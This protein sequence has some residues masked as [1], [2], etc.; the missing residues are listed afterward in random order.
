MALWPVIPH[1]QCERGPGHNFR[2]SASGL[3]HRKNPALK[4]ILQ[5][6]TQERPSRMGA[7]AKLAI[8][9]IA[10]IVVTF[11][12]V[13]ALVISEQ[14]GP[15]RLVGSRVERAISA[16][17]Q[18][19]DVQ[20]AAPARRAGSNKCLS[21]L[22]ERIHEILARSPVPTWG[23]LVYNSKHG[24]ELY[25]RSADRSFVPASGMKLLTAAAAL[26]RLAENFN[27]TTRI[28]RSPNSRN[29]VCLVPVGDPTFSDSHLNSLVRK[30]LEALKLPEGSPIEI[31]VVGVGG[32]EEPPEVWE[33]GDISQPYGAHAGLAV[34]NDNLINVR[35][36]P[37]QPGQPLVASL[38]GRDIGAV[39]L[40]T[41][42][43]MTGADGYGPTLLRVM[44][45]VDADSRLVLKTSGTLSA[46]SPPVW[47]LR[48]ARP[49]GRLLTLHLQGALSEN[50]FG[51]NRA[52]VVALHRHDQ[53]GRCAF[54]ANESAVLAS[55]SSRTLVPLLAR[56]LEYSD[57]L[58]TESL[59]MALGN[60]DRRVGLQ[61]VEDAV[62]DVLETSDAQKVPGALFSMH[63][64]VMMD[65]AG[66]SRQNLVSPRLFVS[67]LEGMRKSSLLRHCLPVSGRSGT[68]AWRMRGTA[69]E[70]I[71]F[72]KT[73]TITGVSSLSGYLAH[74]TL[75]LTTFSIVANNVPGRVKGGSLRSVQDAILVALAEARAADLER[76]TSCE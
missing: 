65:A 42:D 40:D 54:E 52:S 41:S 75:G 2:A 49:A 33:A 35:V 19:P 67:L 31:R 18:G 43:S 13:I 26:N 45:A 12:S 22:E 64:L 66:L 38:F 71:V 21:R 59:M 76:H 56:V 34:I 6:G 20:A 17:Q 61:T 23:V 53:T 32:S 68:L 15:Y 29:A 63:G 60:G 74:L 1:C 55:S 50:G 57:N 44:Y 47:F 3:G 9:F 48:A 7:C 28:Y 69:A 16:Y 24:G 8:A 14:T 73:G 58:Y 39:K 25:S 72:A 4:N 62:R 10:S 27:F 46:N 30:T 70:G 51:P 5:E 11:V 36:S 37:G